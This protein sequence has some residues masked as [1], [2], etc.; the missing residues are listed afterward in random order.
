MGSGS[1]PRKGSCC[2]AHPDA[3]TCEPSH[4]HAPGRS[5]LQFLTVKAISAHGCPFHEN[6]MKC[7]LTI[8]SEVLDFLTCSSGCCT[9]SLHHFTP[10]IPRATYDFHSPS[11]PNIRFCSIQKTCF[12]ACLSLCVLSIPSPLTVPVLRAC[13][14][15][16][17]VLLLGKAGCTEGPG[18][19]MNSTP[20][21]GV[22]CHK[23][24]VMKWES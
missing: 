7:F 1:A 4:R 22:L 13:D 10:K 8:I 3:Q 15:D 17:P 19:A 11:K 12:F 9:T 18:S 5:L 14:R 20:C 16:S 21:L 2:S 6:N 23:R 24:W